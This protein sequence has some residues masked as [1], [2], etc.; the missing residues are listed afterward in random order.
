MDLVVFDHEEL[1]VV[2]RAL[3]Q[4]AASNLTFTKEEKDFVESVALMHGVTAADLDIDGLPPIDPSEAARV[5]RDPH[6]RKRALQLAIVLAFVEGTPSAQTERA[7]EQLASAFE[8]PEK[9]L[10]V[11]R[12]I[13]NGQM[14][15][16]RF[17]MMRRLG[18]AAFRDQSFGDVVKM[19]LTSAGVLGENHALAE[20]Y[21]S[22]AACAPHTIGRALYDHYREHGFAFPGEKNGIPEVGIFHDAGHVLSGYGVDP[23]G[24]IQQA[25][26]QAGFV[27]NDGFVFFLFGVLQFHIGLR[28][29][30]IAK[31]EKG[32]F[33]PK[34]VLRAAQRGAACKVDLSDGWDFWSVKDVPLEELRARYGIPAQ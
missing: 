33:D 8:M 21:R 25:A 28:L 1:V 13:S 5:V 24:E 4:V 31:G 2:L 3:R 23:A 6:K 29:T 10:A 7:V 22:L 26:F 9:A 32:F 34:R 30:P 19:M 11:V 27:R 12:E 16:A 14:T 17:D 18:K 15:L 20:R